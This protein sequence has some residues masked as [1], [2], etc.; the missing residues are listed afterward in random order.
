MTALSPFTVAS[1][2]KRIA[3]ATTQCYSLQA[4]WIVTSLANPQDPSLQQKAGWIKEITPIQC[5]VPS[6]LPVTKCPQI[7]EQYNLIAWYMTTPQTAFSQKQLQKT[8]A[9]IE[10]KA[11]HMINCP[12]T[13]MSQ[14]LS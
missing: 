6:A 14:P 8:A 4:A 2:E 13:P 5:N 3:A 9:T 11:S 12:Q 10:D 7:W 1:Q